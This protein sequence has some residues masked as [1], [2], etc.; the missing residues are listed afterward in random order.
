M[1]EIQKQQEAKEVEANTS[2][3]IEENAVKFPMNIYEGN[4]GDKKCDYKTLAIMTLYSN[5]DKPNEEE[6]KYWRYVYRN[7]L[8]GLSEEIEQL[9]ETKINTILRSVKKLSDLSGG[10]VTASRSEGG[11]IIYTINYRDGEVIRDDD[12]RPIKTTKGSFVLVEE[13]I[14]KYLIHFGSNL[15]IKI[16]L[17]IRGLCEWNERKNGKK[18]M[19]LTRNYICEHIGLSPNSKANLQLIS[20]ATFMLEGSGLIRKNVLKTSVDGKFVSKIYYSIVP[21]NEWKACIKSS[22]RRDEISDKYSK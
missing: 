14:L 22:V 1:K 21:Y 10:L 15:D 18:E 17:F 8:V 11:K 7:K 19:M 6:Y 9:S 2:N 16:Y 20:G 5:N 12:G 3:N 13:D 4:I